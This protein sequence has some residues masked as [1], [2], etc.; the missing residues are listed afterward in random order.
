MTFSQYG[1]FGKHVIA[2]ERCFG[3][4][5]GNRLGLCDG[6]LKQE[7]LIRSHTGTATLVYQVTRELNN[8][9]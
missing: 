7:P 9:K 1:S 5:A 3:I 2:K 8:L 6:K 4:W